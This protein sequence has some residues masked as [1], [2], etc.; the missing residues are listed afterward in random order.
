MIVTFLADSTPMALEGLTTEAVF[1]LA[2]EAQ[3]S[4]SAVIS[5]ISNCVGGCDCDNCNAI[6]EVYAESV[7]TDTLKNDKTLITSVDEKVGTSD[8]VHWWL[9]LDGVDIVEITDNTYGI[10]NNRGFYSSQD[11][12]ST[13]ESDWQSILSTF[14]EGEYRFRVTTTGFSGVPEKT[15]KFSQKYCLSLFQGSKVDGTVLFTWTQN[16]K[17]LNS[18]IDYTGLNLTFYL[19]L[20]GMFG[21]NEP[22]LEIDEIEQSNHSF[23]QI[24]DQVINEYRFDSELLPEWMTIQVLQNMVLSNT[25]TVTD[26][27]FFNHNTIIEKDVRLSTIE[28]PTYFA[29]NKCA[30]LVLKFKER[31]DNIIKRNFF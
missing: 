31:K 4:T 29:F 6:A 28:T 21:F 7:V 30:T 22:T 14:G 9:Q 16:G 11:E 17:I 27:N 19:R 10:F 1:S 18:N 26:Y 23:Q 13:F 2:G 8:E 24:Q 3:P 20:R 12:L 15:E 25:L 5:N